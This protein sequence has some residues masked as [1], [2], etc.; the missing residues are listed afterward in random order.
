MFT[1][2]DSSPKSDV[3][4]HLIF[5]AFPYHLS[6]GVTYS[7]YIMQ[8]DYN[9]VNHLLDRTFQ[10][11]KR[12]ICRSLNRWTQITSYNCS[13]SIGSYK[14][15]H[16]LKNHMRFSVSF[17]IPSKLFGFF[18]NASESMHSIYVHFSYSL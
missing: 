11:Q 7:T 17:H 12:N 3:L 6:F 2:R 13:L 14:L 16:I 1:I 18:N 9:T 4:A 5:G 15:P 8:T 10:K